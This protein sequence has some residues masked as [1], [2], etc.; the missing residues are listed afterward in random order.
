MKKKKHSEEKFLGLL[1]FL[2]FWGWLVSRVFPP[3]SLV[4][5]ITKWALTGF[6]VG[7]LVYGLILFIKA[8]II[9]WNGEN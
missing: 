3:S 2:A 7:L 1:V 5:Q 9:T 6:M 4:F 8:L